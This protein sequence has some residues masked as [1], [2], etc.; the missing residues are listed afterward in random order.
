MEDYLNISM[1]S[2]LLPVLFCVS[3]VKIKDVP[4]EVFDWVTTFPEVT[5][6]S[7]RI[8]RIMNDF[9]SDEHEQKEKHVAN[10]V[11]CYLRQYGCTNEVAH[12]KLKEMV[13]KLWRVF[14]QEL[15]RLRNIPLSFIWII[16]NHARVCNLFY[17]NK[18]EYTNV[19]EDMKDY[20][21]SVMV[22]N[23]TSI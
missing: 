13:E 3:Y 8:G 21:N 14:S 18:D 11:Q 15:L 7:S 19:G 23:V 12:E 17:L 9:V 5:K 6:A 20:V 22:E 2:S 1:R 10:V 16:I 4:R